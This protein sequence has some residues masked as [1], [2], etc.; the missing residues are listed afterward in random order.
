MKLKK[1]IFVILLFGLLSIGIVHWGVE[2]LQQSKFIAG[3]VDDQ[4]GPY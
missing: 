2:Q 1:Y 3:P 4:P